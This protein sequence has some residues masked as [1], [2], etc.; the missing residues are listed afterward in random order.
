MA[1]LL[2]ACSGRS[3]QYNAEQQ[4]IVL[5]HAIASGRFGEE[6]TGSYCG[7]VKKPMALSIPVLPAKLRQKMKWD[8]WRK[9]GCSIHLLKQH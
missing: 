8:G 5:A 1:D 6:N 4:Q 3:G 9:Y 7:R 2:S